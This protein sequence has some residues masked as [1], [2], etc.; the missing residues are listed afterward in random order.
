VRICGQIYNE[1]SDVEQ[2]ADAVLTVDRG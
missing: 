2:L 1:M